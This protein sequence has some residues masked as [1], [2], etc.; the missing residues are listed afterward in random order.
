MKLSDVI[1]IGVGVVGF[2]IVEELVCC[3]FCVRI[4]D[5]GRLGNEVFWVGVG[6]FFLVM[7]VF[8]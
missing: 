4:F 8:V 1:V 7:D 6:I 5:C 2:L 3:G